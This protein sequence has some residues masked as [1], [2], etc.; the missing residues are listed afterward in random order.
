VLRLLEPR[1]TPGAIVAA[2]DITHASLGA[3]LA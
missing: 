3:S 1:L 2:D